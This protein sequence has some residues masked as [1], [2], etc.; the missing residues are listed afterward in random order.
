MGPDHSSPALEGRVRPATPRFA[1]FVLEV[2]DLIRFYDSGPCARGARVIAGYGPPAMPPSFAFL[3]SRWTASDAAIARAGLGLTVIA[4]LHL[5]A[6]GLLL[7]S[8]V[9]I[10]PQ[11]V[12]GF[13][14]GL[15][16]FFWLVVLSRPAVAAA[17][18]LAMIVVLILLS[19]LK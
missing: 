8:E 15:L 13:S 12:F 17:L 1:M 6:L 7:W 16:N 10:V 14:W 9:G 18:S 3:R 4:A 11:L 5:A 19:R 2:T